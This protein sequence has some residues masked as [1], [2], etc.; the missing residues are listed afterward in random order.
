MNKETLKQILTDQRRD[1]L[2]KKTGAI[3][4]KIFEAENYLK[5]PHIYVIS[6]IRRCGKS[7]FLRQIADRFYKN[8]DFFFVNFEDERLYHF[9]AADFN[10]ILEVQIELYG[11]HKTFIIDEIQN[12]QNFELFLRRLGDSGYKFIVSG[13]NAELLS[14][15]ISSKITGRHIE[16]ILRP[17]NFNEYLIFNHISLKE[18]DLYDTEKRAFVSAQFEKFM[19]EGGMPEYLKYKTSEIITRM[20]DDIIIKDIVVRNGITNVVPLRELSRYLVSNFGRR[21]SYNSLQR[22]VGLGSVNTAKSYC[23]FLENAFLINNVTK[24]DYSLKKQLANDKKPYVADHS[25]IRFVSSQL[26][27]DKGRI[28]ENMVGSQLADSNEIYY[29]SNKKECDFVAVDKEKKIR[30]YQVTLVL[31][32]ENYKRETAGLIEA[33]DFFGLKKGTIV[34]S[35]QED[36]IKENGKKIKIVPAWRFVL[37]KKIKS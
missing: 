30:L 21:F 26:H 28:L 19:A 37:Q 22:A 18:H 24:F 23:Q 34:T 3:R 14:G 32:E 20:Y 15:E 16:T 17:F 5:L 11:K 1:F 25:I 29:F 10:S 31:N 33:M 12:V 13:S 35:S 7:T 9:D 8:K 4:E 6:G 2:M 27:N 36:E